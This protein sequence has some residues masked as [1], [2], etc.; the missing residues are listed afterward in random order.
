MARIGFIGLGIM[1]KPMAHNLLKAGHTLVV[2]SRSPGPV[3]ELVEAG[4]TA[5]PN[6]KSVA[7][8]VDILITMLPNSPDVEKVIKGENGVLEGAREGLIIVDMSS[9]APGVAQSLA[10]LAKEKAVTLLDAPVSGGE[11]KAIDGSLAIMVGGPADAFEK[12]Q[13][14]LLNM[15]AS[16]V[17]VGEVGAG[18]ITKLANQVIVGVNI[19]AMSEALTLAAKAGADPAKVV[20]A[21]SGGLAGSTV[22]NMK[23]PMVL[24]GN[25][26][27]GFRIELH[28]K[29]LNNA[30]DT[31]AMVNS[32]LPLSAQVI[33]M[34]KNL[35][36]H[37]HQSDDH[38]GL[39]QYYEERA[40]VK[41]RG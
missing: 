34:M 17:H 4:A 26:K 38:G 40:G 33:T 2:H 9:I 7:E 25:Y 23:A 18:N 29:D 20:D 24:K 27:P 1:G 3:N 11:P 22:L 13:P 41:V 5:A 21:I 31:G 28:I 39:I 15:G 36:E 30:L 8:Q 19:A 6:P 14:I 16:A 35:A 10:K 37:G 12:V 32:P